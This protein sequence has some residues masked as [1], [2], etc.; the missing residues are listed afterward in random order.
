MRRNAGILQKTLRLGTR[1]H[2][3]GKKRRA[4]I[5][6]LVLLGGLALAGGG[7]AG[8]YYEGSYGAGYYA[9]DY[10]P[11][12]GE[13]GYGGAPFFGYGGFFGGPDIIVN[14]GYHRR[15]YGYHHFT[16][17]RGSYHHRGQV[18]ITGRW[19]GSLRPLP[20][21]PHTRPRGAS[22]VSAVSQRQRR[23]TQ[24][25]ATEADVRGAP[26]AL[27]L[28]RRLTREFPASAPTPGGPRGADSSCA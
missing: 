18:F 11:Y 28:N 26:A 19:F 1:L 13:Y 20:S 2:S 22:L 15:Y 27:R 4:R 24:P 21:L 14:S 10:G 16:Q 25:L 12:Y 7:C 6:A 5:A 3:L 8:G 17:E 9:P 23:I